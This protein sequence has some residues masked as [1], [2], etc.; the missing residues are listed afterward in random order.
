MSDPK[1]Q[2]G[3]ETFNVLGAPNDVQRPENDTFIDG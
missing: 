3:V 1:S 2:G